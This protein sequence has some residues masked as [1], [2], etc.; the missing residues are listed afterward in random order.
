M[1]VVHTWRNLRGRS[2]CTFEEVEKELHAKDQEELNHKRDPEEPQ[3]QASAL[4]HSAT[5]VSSHGVEDSF[6]L[7]CCQCR[8]HLHG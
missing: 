1:A 6:E 4:S 3:R 2:R 5:T 8:S 7:R